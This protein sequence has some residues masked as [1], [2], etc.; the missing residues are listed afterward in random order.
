MKAVPR[1][2]NCLSSL[3]R[4]SYGLVLTYGTERREE[5]IRSIREAI[6]EEQYQSTPSRLQTEDRG[7]VESEDKGQVESDWEGK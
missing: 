7:Q 3:V 4:V 6:N 2:M 5:A 1:A